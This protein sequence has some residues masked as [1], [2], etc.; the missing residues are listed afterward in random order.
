MSCVLVFILKILYCGYTLNLGF[1]DSEESLLL[2]EEDNSS[3]PFDA[4]V[5]CV[6]SCISLIEGCVG[7]PGEDE[8][9][10]LAADPDELVLLVDA[11]SIS[12][13]P[14]LPVVVILG[15]L[16][17]LVFVFVVV[18]LLDIVC[19]LDVG[20]LFALVAVP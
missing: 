16:A 14:L 6:S 3:H 9:V 15:V 7:T 12:L 11:A 19:L 17:V 20:F 2:D 1:S 18:L 10:D 5:C 4:R 8:L 13:K